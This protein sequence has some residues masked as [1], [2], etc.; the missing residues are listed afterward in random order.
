MHWEIN[1]A[2][3]ALRE[4]L[5]SRL[6][7]SE[8]LADLL[9]NRGMTDLEG[10]R[11]FLDPNLDHLLDPF[12][13]PDMEQA[14]ERIQRAVR[15]REK[16][17]IYG[18]YDVDGIS[19]TALLLHFFRLLGVEADYYIPNR[20][21]EGYSMNPKAVEEI[22]RRGI[23]LVVS[24]DNGTGA[25]AEIASLREQGVDVVVTDHH[26]AEGDLPDACAVVNPKRED[27]E[28][29]FR[30]LAGVGV[31]FKVASA[32]SARFTPQ[33]K[34]S[35]E[36]RQFLFDSLG[37]AAMGTISDVV[38]LI[39][40]NRVIARYGLRALAASDLPGIRELLKVSKVAGDTVAPWDVGFRIGPRLNA[41]GR[42]GDA[43]MA[44]GLLVD[45]DV[46]SARETALR[47]DR[48]NTRR[49]AIE[50]A[51]VEECR[52][53][54]KADPTLVDRRSIVLGDASWHRGV[55]GIV[56][57]KLAGEFHRP[58][59]L[60]SFEGE[61]QGRGSARS[62]PGFNILEAIRESSAVLKAFGGHAFAA[63]LEIHE[64]DLPTFARDFDEAT[65]RLNEDRDFAPRLR[66][67]REIRFDEIR[68]DLMTELGRLA[69]HGEQN[70]APLFVARRVRV[71]GP[72][73][74]MG[75][76]NQHIQM[77][78]N[79]GETSF[80]VIGFGMARWIETL[81]DASIIDVAF[82]PRLQRWSGRESIELHLR[83]I[84]EV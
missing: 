76:R 40:E 30:L 6:G 72:P 41:A 18:D 73:K 33:R 57:A 34:N 32:L 81:H 31:A 2:N 61:G 50:R 56:A 77:W 4:E 80:R 38:P 26:E 10:A 8:V 64:A 43:G 13:L 37:L 53:R 47:I 74:I 22:V 55:L 78:L 9:A 16:I 68:R 25:S 62:V 17:L 82:H 67:D 66:V 21:T 51:I 23:G 7:I 19:G 65:S 70:P 83:D 44:L 69:P 54:L 58:T 29:P 63:G 42:L 84:R 20:L 5:T 3:P 39:G 15:E 52:E 1:P 49:Q 45:T 46:D 14:V 60:F 11:E 27:S 36:F 79:Q 35:T 71:A 12:L 75:R 59:I 28:Y 24:I 48:D